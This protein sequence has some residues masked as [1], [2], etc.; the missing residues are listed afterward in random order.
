MSR[1]ITEKVIG[2]LRA[3]PRV[4]SLSGDMV[5]I[6]A[7][8][9]NVVLQVSDLSTIVHDLSGDN[10]SVKIQSLSG[11]IATINSNVL[12]C[13]LPK[14]KSPFASLYVSVVA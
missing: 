1:K 2:R 12:C 9:S 8:L 3:V 6:T 4:V 11:E 7:G 14:S 10:L 5:N 13:I